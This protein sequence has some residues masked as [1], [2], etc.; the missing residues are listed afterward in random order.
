MK[1]T[2]IFLYSLL[3]FTPLKSTPL[4][5]HGSREVRVKPGTLVTL[6]LAETLNTKNLNKDYFFSLEV[7]VDVVVN[8][9]VVI[10]NGAYAEGYVSYFLSKRLF[11][12]GSEVEIRALNV[13]CIDGQRAILNG[14]PFRQV[15]DKRRTR[16][17]L[18]MVLFGGLIILVGVIIN[19]GV[20]LVGAIFFLS[21]VFMQGEETE[22][23]I[24]TTLTATLA[25][26]IIVVVD[27]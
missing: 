6:K 5:H 2:L 8:R 1:Y 11:G 10:L 13:Q 22:I 20:V 17:A 15:A 25:E 24:S 9:E 16:F 26:E 18:S 21:G 19:W 27:N 7:Y 3:I 4:I 23:P 14:T 12:K